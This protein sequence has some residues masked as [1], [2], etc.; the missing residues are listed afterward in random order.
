MVNKDVWKFLNSI[1]YEY[2]YAGKYGAKGEKR[3][4]RKKATPEQIKKQNQ[5]NREKRMRRL[6]KAN[7]SQGD[8]WAALKYPEGARIPLGEVKKHLRA[9]LAAMRKEYKKRGETF[10]F[11]YRMEIG[12]R[13][14]IHIHI[15]VNRSRG[16]PDTDLLMQAVWTHGRVNFQSIYEAGGYKKLAD[17]IVKQPDEE[18]WEQLSMFPKP[19]QKEL[20]KYSSSRNLIRP[21]P[22]RHTYKRS[23]IR[24]LLKE[25]PEPTPGYYIDR[26]SIECGT[27][28]YTGLSY[29]HY[30]EVRID[31][32]S[33]GR[34]DGGGDSS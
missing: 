12:K 6:I 5:K 19:E 29:Y 25:G 30:T 33:R 10:K 32:W 16:K 15:L 2:K 20:I 3:A 7:F 23:P 1:E 24:R 31:E 4:K 26:D 11:V 22:E 28:P 34:P 8:I 9:F 14:G 13:G 18:V 21:A 17:Y 27:N